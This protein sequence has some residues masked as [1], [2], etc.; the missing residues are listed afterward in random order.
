MDDDPEM[1]DAPIPDAVDR[2]VEVADMM[3]VFAAQRLW[4]VEAMRQEALEEAARYGRAL[5]D[6]VERGV[7]LELAAALRITE[8]AAGEM[9]ARAAAMVRRYPSVLESLGRARMTERHAEVLVDLIDEVE[10]ELRAELVPQAIELAEQHAVGSFRRMLRRLIET[11]RSVSLAERHEAALER[12]RVVVEPA[13]DAMAWL[14]AYLPA[15]EAQAIFGRA[16]A[17]AKTIV[18]DE[19]ESRTLDQVRA[20]VVCDLL[21]EGDTASLPS[22]ARGIRASVVVTVP[23]LALLEAGERERD[24]AGLAPATVEGVGPIPLA[25]A[26]QLCG[27]EGGWMRVLTHPESGAVL[28]AGREL[29]RPPAAL[30][31]LVK[32]RADRCMAP[33]CGMPASRCEIDH[34]LA[35]ADGGTTGI[36]NLAP[37]CRGHHRVKHHGGWR[38]RQI[39]DSGGEIEWTSPTGRRYTVK[40][41]RRHPVFHPSASGDAPF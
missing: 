27:G 5:T 39:P 15:V 20:D 31:R 4:S 41:E 10:P 34:T 40:P 35:W 22:D 24:A 33:G 28:S 23:A 38:V 21:I 36:E 6:V 30:A 18:A 14:H 37:I 32:W 2:V 29:Y 1:F 12:R 26:R 8:Q 7:R 17:M 13:E 19:S 9:I 11:V 16:T 3:A 25:R